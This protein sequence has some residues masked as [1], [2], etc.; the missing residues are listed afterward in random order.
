MHAALALLHRAYARFFLGL[1]ALL[2]GGTAALPALAQSCT[3]DPKP[4]IFLRLPIA[5]MDS[6]TGI[7]RSFANAVGYTAYTEFSR[8]LAAGAKVLYEED[9]I[10][11]LERAKTEQLLGTDAVGTSVLLNEVVPQSSLDW[12]VLV[13]LRPTVLGNQREMVLTLFDATRRARFDRSRIATLPSDNS[14]VGPFVASEVRA[15]AQGLACTLRAQRGAPVQPQV[16]LAVEPRPPRGQP[17]DTLTVRATLVD[18]ANNG[19]PV[20]NQR[21]NVY[22]LTPQGVRERRWATTD[23]N[24]V[25]TDRYVLGAA[26]P[27]AG[28][29]EAGFVDIR[30]IERKS[31]Q[32]NYYVRPAGGQLNLSTGKAQLVPTGGDT[33][34]AELRHNGAPVPATAVNLSATAGAV[35]SASV[36]TSSAGLAAVPYVAP[37]TPALVDLRATTT[38]P[39]GAGPAS[40]SVSYVV[41]PGVV[42]T[43]AAGGDTVVFGASSMR[44]DLERE[45]RAVTGATVAF[46]VVG[47]GTLS[48]AS[49]ATDSVGRAETLFGAP[50]RAGSST[51]TASVTL[52]GRTYTR[53]VTVR[54]S[55]PLDAITREI[56]DVKEA[57]WLDP[58]DANLARLARIRDVL[59]GRNEAPRAEAML[60]D[61]L[62]RGQLYC[63]HQRAHDECAAGLRNKGEATLGLLKAASAGSTV[64]Q[65]LFDRARVSLRACPYPA[66][67]NH[68]AFSQ[69]VV[70]NDIAR[71]STWEMFLGL[72][73]G[74]DDRIRGFSF[75]A[76]DPTDPANRY[77]HGAVFTGHGTT[78]FSGRIDSGGDL[79]GTWGNRFNMIEYQARSATPTVAISVNGAT[80]SA[81]LELYDGEYEGTRRI[82]TLSFAA[83]MVLPNPPEAGMCRHRALPNPEAGRAPP[84][85]VARR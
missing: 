63:T 79:R 11:N 10:N 18:L 67:M 27:R 24:G 20:A 73:W 7:T 12:I 52:D 46:S 50:S 77:A 33:V 54:Y 80:V 2:L 28:L 75:S 35:G 85:P 32:I 41:D 78:S 58:S 45:Q 56:A 70:F 53:S 37:A 55:D 38:L 49:V 43:F 65:E 26:H 68:A 40:A 44:V 64:V 69:A 8:A 22:Y 19:A 23:A 4:Y 34:S 31:Q 42:M 51:V 39:G 17:G 62:V 14:L 36:I 21:I 74:D 3:G 72:S 13:R 47:G 15:F 9:F 6:A 5:T 57:I 81:S 1:A 30:G 16:R 29:I 61:S 82:A 66:F 48:A 76:N 59:L 71:T 84:A 83:T 60:N 25:A